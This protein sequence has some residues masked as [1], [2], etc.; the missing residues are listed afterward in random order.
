MKMKKNYFKLVTLLLVILMSITIITGC[1]KSDAPTGGNVSNNGSNNNENKGEGTDENYDG[2]LVFD[3][4]LELKYAKNFSV[5]Y[6]KGGYK[7]I[8]VSDGSEILTVPEGM[9]VP[10]EV[11]E[12]VIVLKMPVSNML[13]SSTPTMSLI[14]SIGMLD[15]ITLTTTER[16]DWYIDEVI[17][18]M[19][20]SSITFAGSYKAPD[21]EILTSYAPPFAVFSGMLNSTPEVGEKLKELKIPYML[22]MAS[23]E[24]HPLARVE[25][26]K[27]YG[28]LYD[29]EEKAN[30]VFDAQVAYVDNLDTAKVTDKTVAMFYITSKGNL[31]V[32]QGGDYMVKM[33]ELAGA[34]YI[35]SD[36][37][38]DKTGTE[39]IEF[40]EFYN[41]AK[42]ADYI[43]YIWSLGG[44]PKNLDDFLAKNEL[45]KDLKAVKD[46]NV[47]CT[48]PDY[49]QISDTLGHMIKDMNDMLTL[50]DASVDSFQ[51]LIRLK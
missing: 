20:N 21:Y 17:E 2:K 36:L 46:G 44:K 49:F 32:R 41:T 9:S 34:K 7:L 10:A 15:R 31:H 27:L 23:E 45:F 12:N 19:D 3:Y 50:E 1:S 18:K 11:G 22:D 24:V 43:I 5:D 51:H 29:C 30:E 26:V 16:D 25:W 13:I 6:Y 37:N 47:W 4:S 8:K 48:T 38:P 35:F 14:N 40:E 39:K 42:D 33:L 28:A